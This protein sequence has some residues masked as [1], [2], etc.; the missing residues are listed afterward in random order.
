MLVLIECYKMEEDVFTPTGL[1]QEKQKRQ[2]VSD[3]VSK[4][5]SIYYYLSSLLASVI[6]NIVV[7]PYLTATY[8]SDL[9][10]F[11]SSSYDCLRKTTS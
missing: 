1:Q 4:Y 9:P 8:Y 10:W 11:Y 7:T 5:L 2:L 6:Y 3:I